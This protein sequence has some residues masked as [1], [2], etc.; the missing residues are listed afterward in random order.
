MTEPNRDVLHARFSIFIGLNV[1]DPD[2]VHG[3]ALSDY[4]V[5]D[6]SSA[7]RSLRDANFQRIEEWTPGDPGEYHADV[8]FLGEEPSAIDDGAEISRLIDLTAD[9]DATLGT[10]EPSP[11]RPAEA[12]WG[13]L[14]HGADLE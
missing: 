10:M 6:L 5:T 1:F 12:P 13:N 2:D 8:E 11:Q 3:P 14:E 7:D 9:G 4:E